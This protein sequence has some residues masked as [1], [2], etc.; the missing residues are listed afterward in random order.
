LHRNLSHGFEHFI[1]RYLAETIPA[2]A[3]SAASKAFAAPE[4]LRFTQGISTNP[5]TGSQSIRHLSRTYYF[6]PAPVIYILPSE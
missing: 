2:R 4:A 1:N 3:R 5:A 6:T